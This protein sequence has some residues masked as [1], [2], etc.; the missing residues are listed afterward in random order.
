MSSLLP[1]PAT[2]CTL[3]GRT[4]DWTV[5]ITNVDEVLS[6]L[7]RNPNLVRRLISTQEEI[8][9]DLVYAEDGLLLLPAE[10]VQPPLEQKPP[11]A[12]LSR[13]SAL[14]YPF[15]VD[16][17][18]KPPPPR[19][20]RPKKP[21]PEVNT[22]KAPPV[23]VD[24]PKTQPDVVIVDPLSDLPEDSPE[25][26][27]SEQSSSSSSA[28][29]EPDFEWASVMAAF[30]YNPEDFVD[31]SPPQIEEYD[32]EEE[33]APTRPQRQKK[34]TEF[35]LPEHLQAGDADDEADEEG[36]VGKPKG[37]G[38][39]RK[40]KIIYLGDCKPKKAQQHLEL[41]AP[42]VLD[43][44]QHDTIKRLSA[45][46]N[47]PHPVQPMPAFMR[48]TQPFPFVSA[49]NAAWRCWFFNFQDACL[50]AVSMLWSKRQYYRP[51]PLLPPNYTELRETFCTWRERAYEEC[52]QKLAETS[53]APDSMLE[54]PDDD[55]ETISLLR[56][57]LH[58]HVIVWRELGPDKY[59]LQ[60][61][62]PYVHMIGSVPDTR[63]FVVKYTT[64]FQVKTLQCAVNPWQLMLEIAQQYF[65]QLMAPIT[66]PQQRKAT[67]PLFYER[68]LK[69]D[70]MIVARA[71]EC[72]KL[73]WLYQSFFKCTVAW[74]LVEARAR[75]PLARAALTLPSGR[76]V[77]VH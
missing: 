8:V 25:E 62:I 51:V 42:A 38:G 23:V 75:E 33:P 18:A 7:K 5:S 6:T 55:T 10:G 14:C 37:K 74:N 68:I 57:A 70:E 4:I 36:W 1:V 34:Q 52:N 16:P 76:R 63:S 46:K 22:P 64:L 41:P 45:L 20:P 15:A 12:V 65:G 71:A 53:F 77:G 48:F 40:K 19:Q 60:F 24:S 35:L 73:W 50:T 28:I 49:E 67:V 43:L 56:V 3:F 58:Y 2:E 66:K 27:A 32:G 31:D 9:D 26:V 59:F 11:N 61:S 72:F 44:M 29:P 13:E 47:A 39:K 69:A 17:T 30:A 21:P 54:E